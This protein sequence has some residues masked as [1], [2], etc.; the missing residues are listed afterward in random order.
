MRAIVFHRRAA[1]YL[2]RMPRD[3]AVQVR[4]ALREVAALA[5]IADY[6]SKILAQDAPATLWSVRDLK[7]GIGWQIRLTG[8]RDGARCPLPGKMYFPPSHAPRCDTPRP[9]TQISTASP[10]PIFHSTSKA[11]NLII[12]ALKD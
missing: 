10:C 2:S 8:G 3:R 6:S 11:V 9:D 1:R 4:D 5:N 12:E 7:K